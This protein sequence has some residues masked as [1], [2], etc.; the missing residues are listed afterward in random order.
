MLLGEALEALGQIEEADALYQ[1]TMSAAKR[2]RDRRSYNLALVNHVWL[3]CQ[4]DPKS[5]EPDDVRQT[6]AGAIGVFEELGD[7][8]GLAR[9][10]GLSGQVDWTLCRYDEAKKA[11]ER[12]L[13]HGRRASDGHAGRYALIAINGE[14]LRGSTPVD[15][16]ISQV[17]SLMDE[18]A[19]N[20]SLNANTLCVLAALHSRG[21]FARSLPR[22][23]DDP[24]GDGSRVSSRAS[25]MF[26][27][28][29]GLLAGDADFAARELRRA[30]DLLEARGEHGWR[31]TVAAMLAEALV[32]L[33]R[34][35]EA[36]KYAD[37]ALSVAGADDITSQARGRIVKAKV[38]AARGDHDAAERLAREA[39]ELGARSD[40]LF[41]QSRLLM[42]LAEVLRR[43]G[44]DAAVPVLH[45]AV[46]VSERKKP[47]YRGQRTC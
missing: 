33:E 18:S 30:H 35:S 25:S 6:A 19:R 20:A 17:E 41:M 37:V 21:D 24:R 39:V 9:A 29:V 22:G 46:E 8:F 40:D 4:I 44:R 3:S 27:E 43:S 2:L 10:W 5:W 13:L 32:M 14:L 38:L 11:D 23:K 31:S 1:E 34:H 28:E 47:R 45:D 26:T 42:G 15:E 36:E 16:A 7:D 12:V